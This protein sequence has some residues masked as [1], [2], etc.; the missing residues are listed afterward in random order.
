MM[1]PNKIRKKYHY[2]FP[3]PAIFYDRVRITHWHLLKNS[4]FN[5]LYYFLFKSIKLLYKKKKE[6][7]NRWQANHLHE[8]IAYINSFCVKGY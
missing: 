8:T 6:N 5:S 4:C 2:N 7:S 1:Q 3:W